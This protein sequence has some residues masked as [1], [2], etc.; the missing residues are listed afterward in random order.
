MDSI[1]A[2]RRRPQDY[3]DAELASLADC[4]GI[5]TA[6]VMAK[7]A[8][9]AKISESVVLIRGD[10]KTYDQ[11]V[12]TLHEEK[13][14]GELAEGAAHGVEVTMPILGWLEAGAVGVGGGVAL[15]VAAVAL[16]LH[17]LIAASEHG[18]ELRRALLRDEVHAAMLCQ[19]D[20]PRGFRGHELE[21][22]SSRGATFQAA[23]Q[24]MATQMGGG[25]HALMACI[26]L[27]CD[28]GMTAARRMIEGC[29]GL[30][31][32]LAAHAD[33]ARRY[34]EDAAYK[35]GFDAMVWAR[36]EGTAEYEEAARS[37]R[38][39]VDRYA[40]AGVPLKG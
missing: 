12:A 20:L 14:L 10:D 9:D 21:R 7:V 11:Y 34:R 18:R 26:Q 36:K 31:A 38:A 19:L 13:R 24:K 5:T 30:G 22:Y 39:R 33:V 35:A 29:H 37:L 23:T 17:N 40:R 1:S 28:E 32:F 8:H 16:G 27:H 4:P 2:A 6:S 25:N 15:P 3:S